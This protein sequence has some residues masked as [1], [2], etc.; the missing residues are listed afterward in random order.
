METEEDRQRA[1]IIESL[2]Q[3]YFGFE[4]INQE[5]L[6]EIVNSHQTSDE[7]RDVYKNILSI[8]P[9]VRNLGFNVDIVPLPLSNDGIYWSDYADTYL[10]DKYKKKFFDK[11]VM[12]FKKKLD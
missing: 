2:K 9:L 3:D 12:Y 6:D 7:V 10:D 1:N 11:E 5:K 8:I 4:E